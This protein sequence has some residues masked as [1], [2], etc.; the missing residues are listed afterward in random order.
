MNHTTIGNDD[1]DFNAE[2][3]KFWRERFADQ[4]HFS[5]PEYLDT[6]ED[7]EMKWFLLGYKHAIYLLRHGRDDLGMEDY[8]RS[9]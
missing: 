3:E 7:K 2:I 6:E 4:L 5:T 8:D 9:D 1:W